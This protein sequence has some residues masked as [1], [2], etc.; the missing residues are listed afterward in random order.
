MAINSRRRIESFPR[1]VGFLARQGIVNLRQNYAAQQQNFAGR[2]NDPLAPRSGSAPTVRQIIAPGSGALSFEQRTG[3]S[4]PV[5][6][7]S[8]ANSDDASNA[9]STRNNGGRSSS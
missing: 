3:S 2:Q 1:Q 4:A 8:A 9:G 5:S 7:T 6:L